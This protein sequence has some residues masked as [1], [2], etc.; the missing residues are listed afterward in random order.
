MKKFELTNDTKIYGVK[1]Y[2]ELKRWLALEML[3][4]MN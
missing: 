1:N 3:K 2:L 4:K